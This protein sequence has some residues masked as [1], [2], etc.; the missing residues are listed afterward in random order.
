MCVCV[1]VCVWDVCMYVVC[2]LYVCYVCV[3]C[4]YMVC[5]YMLCVCVHLYKS[6]GPSASV[7]TF[8]RRLILEP[9]RFYAFPERRKML[10][11]HDK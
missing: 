8:S 7:S 3:L 6:T 5:V 4:V 1:C 11:G 9:R 2:V 10:R